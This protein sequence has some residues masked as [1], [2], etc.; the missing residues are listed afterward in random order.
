MIRQAGPRGRDGR[1]ERERAQRP[2]I[3]A[4]ARWAQAL[5]G[6][7]FERSPIWSKPNCR[8]MAVPPRPHGPYPQSTRKADGKT[9]TR[10]QIPRQL[11][12]HDPW[13]FLEARRFRGFLS[14]LE[15][16]SRPFRPGVGGL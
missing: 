4:S 3:V 9:G 15:A 5:L 8:F 11:D 6:S 10:R 1:A 13:G 12:R 7:L 2:A 16:L 14:E